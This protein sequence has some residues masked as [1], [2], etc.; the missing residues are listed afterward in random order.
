MVFGEPGKFE[1]IEKYGEN[2][3]KKGTDMEAKA[4]GIR[5]EGI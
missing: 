2:N 1:H 4:V 3:R 5:G